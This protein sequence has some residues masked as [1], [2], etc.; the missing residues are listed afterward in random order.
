MAGAGAAWRARRK[1]RSEPLPGTTNP[2]DIAMSNAGGTAGQALV[3]TVLANQDRLIDAQI[4]Q[5]GRLRWR[6]GVFALIGI[7]LI[8][9]AAAFV[10]SASRAEGIVLAPFA[11]PPALAERGV[12][13]TVVASQLLDRLT[14]MQAETLSIRPASSYGDDWSGNIKVE[15]PYAGISLGELRRYLVGALGKQ[16]TLSGEVVSLADGR[17][18]LATRIS[19]SPGQR[20]EG[21][22]LEALVRKAAEGIYKDTQAY[23]YATWLGRQQ[24]NA[25]AAPLVHELSR[26][27]DPIER[28]WAYHLLALTVKTDPAREFALYRKAASIDP[29]FP[30]T[31]S[32]VSSLQFQLGHLEDGCRNAQRSD[33]MY[34]AWRGRMTAN[35]LE[36]DRLG[37]LAKVAAC[38]GDYVLAAETDRRSF[39]YQADYINGLAA[40]LTLAAD[41]ADYHDIDAA[42]EVVADAG[43]DDPATLEA[44]LARVGRLSDP[45]LSVAYAIRDWP[46]LR[47]RLARV[48]AALVGETRSNQRGDP[49]NLIATQMAEALARTGRDAEAAARLARTPLDCDYCLRARGLAAAFAGRPV[50]ADRWFGTLAR[51]TPSLPYA[52]EA[53]AEAMLLRRDYAGAVREATA[54]HALGPRWAE[55]LK[56]W[57]DALAAQGRRADAAAKYTLALE[58][59]PKWVAL[60][61]VRDAAVRRAKG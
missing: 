21:A 10:W 7:L 29:T 41:Y 32:N 53:W 59:A 19:G 45:E 26:S 1:L 2:I 56:Y 5:L 58:R 37:N 15:L 30:P 33:A 46:R 40:P 38:H 39:E 22:D 3:R 9:A 8:A 35:R 17:V 48:S 25:E 42:R 11:V 60:Q 57:G 54:A 47:D 61:R 6:D 49:T 31:A 51:R 12:T 50:E 14:A 13:G 24:R 36:A 44:T 20:Y 52:H 16:R 23:R 34:K 43:L 4:A 55:P 27:A 28:M 18:A